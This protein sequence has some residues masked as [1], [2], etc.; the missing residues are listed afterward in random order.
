L[1][2]SNSK[3]NKLIEKYLGKKKDLVPVDNQGVSFQ[4]L[5][6]FLRLPNFSIGF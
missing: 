3:A 6:Y 1:Y 5:R 4:L 2:E